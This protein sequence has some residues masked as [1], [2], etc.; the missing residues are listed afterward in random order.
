MRIVHTAGGI[1]I[2]VTRL[3]ITVRNDPGLAKFWA[4][5]KNVRLT[6]LYA[7]LP[8]VT[9]EEFE[10]I[11]HNLGEDIREDRYLLVA[12]AMKGLYKQGTLDQFL[13][14]ILKGARPKS[15]DA[16]L[17]C[18]HPL[19]LDWDRTT[20]QVRATRT[21]PEIE[22]EAMLAA[23]QQGIYSLSNLHPLVEKVSERLFLDGHYSQAIFEA[24]KAVISLV[25][26]KSGRDDL[27]GQKLMATVFSY[28]NPILR[29]NSLRT[30]SEQNEQMGFMFLF[31]GATVGIRNPKAH[32]IIDQAD[33]IRA[34]EYLALAS[35]L[36]RRVE[37]STLPPESG[38]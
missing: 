8:T 32:D 19:G 1:G 20:N 15:P 17:Q 25:K 22:K 14:Q 34:L 2:Y 23:D 29:L 12:Q 27:D 35:L 36:A 3:Y 30:K 9:A 28:E 16:F 7:G 31:M 24:Y 21:P 26:E 18:L 5:W 13:T 6:L 10:L 38:N 4:E 33:Q 11:Y 37:E